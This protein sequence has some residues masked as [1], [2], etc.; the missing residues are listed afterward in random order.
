MPAQLSPTSKSRDPIRPPTKT[1]GAYN[2]P[3]RPQEYDPVS[4]RSFRTSG[5]AARND[6]ALSQQVHTAQSFEEDATRSSKSNVDRNLNRQQGDTLS[7]AR[8]PSIPRKQVGALP[9]SLYTSSHSPSASNIQT[10][11][12]RPNSASNPLPSPRDKSHGHSNKSADNFY[13]P[14]GTID[15][16]RQTPKVPVGP[17]D[18]QEVVNH[19]KYNTY[20]TQVVETVAPG[21]S[22]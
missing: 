8:K 12:R 2:T 3:D 16:S 21:Q 13:H 15:R 18:T 9:G 6:I 14:S 10:N 17:Q 19:A 4:R 7:P 11:H 1:I 20:D 5:Y 22:M